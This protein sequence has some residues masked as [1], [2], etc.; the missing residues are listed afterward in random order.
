[1][2]VV[3][4]KVCLKVN[5]EKINYMAMYSKQNAKQNHSKEIRNKFDI[6]G[7]VHRR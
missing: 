1:M 3:A 5:V 4:R 6:H 2:S 7:S